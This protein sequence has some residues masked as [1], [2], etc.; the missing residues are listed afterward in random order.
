MHAVL[1]RHPR[2]WHSALH[3]TCTAVK[4]T[5]Y[6]NPKTGRG[7]PLHKPLPS[8]LSARLVYKGFLSTSSST[9]FLT[10]SEEGKAAGLSLILDL[11][12]G[13]TERLNN[14]PV[15]HSR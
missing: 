7:S 6:T 3:F 14:W 13:S 5:S 9:I 10:S 11:R 1:A 2:P 4:H 8:C 15:S 12:K